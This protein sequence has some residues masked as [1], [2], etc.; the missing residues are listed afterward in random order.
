MDSP[1]AVTD[2]ERCVALGRARD[3]S[4]LGHAFALFVMA[5]VALVAGGP[6]WVSVHSNPTVLVVGMG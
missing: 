3:S 4:M 2:R 5:I 6:L 1:A